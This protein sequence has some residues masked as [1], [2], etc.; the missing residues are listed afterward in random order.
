MGQ[1][2]FDADI[3]T[4][5]EALSKS[6]A[7]LSSE[8]LRVLLRERAGL[9]RQHLL[10]GALS[11]S[12]TILAI[13]RKDGASIEDDV[14]AHCKFFGEVMRVNW[15]VRERRP[16]PMEIIDTLIG[17]LEKDG[18]PVDAEKKADEIESNILL[19][20]FERGLSGP[21][22]SP[23]VG[24]FAIF[25]VY[26]KIAVASIPKHSFVPGAKEAFL[27]AEKAVFEAALR[28]MI[29]RYKDDVPSKPAPPKSSPWW[30]SFAGSFHRGGPLGS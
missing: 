7:E 5:V 17:F 23:A 22:F 4:Q 8:I 16:A 14:D 26:G 30:K 3:N 21:N 13:T 29:E 12:A 20:I 28:A 10:A 9:R 25:L 27:S 24:A 19:K 15:E 2:F 18:T 6:G 11:A 1:P